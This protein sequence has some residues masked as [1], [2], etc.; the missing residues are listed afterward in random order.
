MLTHLQGPTFE[1][2][3]SELPSLLL[4]LAELLEALLQ[5]IRPGQDLRHGFNQARRNDGGFGLPSNFRNV[6]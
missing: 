4:S 2:S 1:L 6:V 5:G 3:S